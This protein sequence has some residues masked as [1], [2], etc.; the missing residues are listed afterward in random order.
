MGEGEGEEAAGLDGAGEV[1]HGGDGVFHVHDGHDGDRDVEGAEGGGKG[2]HE[3][4]D[5]VGDAERRALLVRSGDVDQALGDI[6]GDDGGAAAGQPAGVAAAGA[7]DLED[8]QS[9][10]VCGQEDVHGVGAAAAVGAG[11]V[12]GVEEGGGGAVPV[13]E[14]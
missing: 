5:A 14:A 1:L 6:H 7:G 9:I 8:A 2:L 3:V 10:Q 13:R 12:G 4:V 11:A